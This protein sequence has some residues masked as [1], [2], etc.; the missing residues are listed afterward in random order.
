MGFDNFTRD[1][2]SSKEP[3]DLRIVTELSV[4]SHST[5]LMDMYHFQVT[6]VLIIFVPVTLVQVAISQ[7]LLIRS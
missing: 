4:A 3:E 2:A 5:F 1:V 7:E 6:F